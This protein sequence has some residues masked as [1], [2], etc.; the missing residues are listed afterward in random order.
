MQAQ[1]PQRLRWSDL[2]QALADVPALALSFG[3]FFCLLCGYFMLRSIR[4]AFGATDD[5][6]A[7][8]P[9]A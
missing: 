5:A 4:D 2:K 3:Y 6:S 7:V 9:R 8:F 1:G